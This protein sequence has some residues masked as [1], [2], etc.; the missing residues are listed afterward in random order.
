MLKKYGW[1]KNPFDPTHPHPEFLIYK[2]QT[3][4]IIEKIKE[5]R[6]VWINAPMGIGKTTILRYISEYGHK[7]GLHVFYWHYGSNPK[8]EEFKQGAQTL[9]PTFFEKHIFGC[10]TRAI[11]IDE[12]NYIEDAEFYRYLVGLL[13]D[14]KIFP[15]LVFASVTGP[16]EEILFKTFKDRPLETMSIKPVTDEEL[17]AMVEK[18]IKKVGGKGLITPFDKE[19]VLSIIRTTDTPRGVL[20]KLMMLASGKSFVAKKESFTTKVSRPMITSSLLETHEEGGSLEFLSAQQRK[21]A[22]LLFNGPMSLNEIAEKLDVKKPSAR[23]QL[24]RLASAKFLKDK[25]LR[26]PIIEKSGNMWR[27]HREYKVAESSP[28]KTTSVAVRAVK[29]INI[30]PI[31]GKD[32]S[33]IEGEEAIDKLLFERGAVDGKTAIDKDIIIQELCKS[34]NCDREKAESVFAKLW[35]RGKIVYT[36]EEE[37][38]FSVSA[39]LR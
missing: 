34:L 8:V 20:E 7:H 3:E 36:K 25:G 30:E 35:N 15:S 4:E 21:I 11:L 17:L 23:V 18:R 22:E 24:Y 29:K 32:S 14:P 2:Q 19:T 13:D 6:L 37:K 38:V 27:I 31:S 1:R 10:K 16:P 39:P 5:N 9:Y 12:A 26:R 28:R 33:K